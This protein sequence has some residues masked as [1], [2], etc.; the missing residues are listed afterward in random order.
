M[1]RLLP[2]MAIQAAP[3]PWDAGATCARFEA[4]LRELRRCFPRTHLFL[5]PELYLHA[6]GGLARPAPLFQP[7]A[8]REQELVLARAN[9]IANQVFVVNVNVAGTPGPGSSIIVDPEGHPLQVAGGGEEYLSQV[10]DLDAVTAV[11]EHGS[12]GLNRLWAQ[13][14][15]EGPALEL[16][17]YGDRF[18]PRPAAPASGPERG[19]AGRKR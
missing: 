12:V 10:L 11:R 5:Y 14:E 3:V 16:P 9:A 8:D 7:S 6:L 4:E 2:M 13:L 19:P 17:C 1:S 15:A 18:R